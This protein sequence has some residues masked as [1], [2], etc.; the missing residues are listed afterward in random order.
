MAGCMTL[1]AIKLTP[2]SA[3]VQIDTNN[4]VESGSICVYVFGGQ[5]GLVHIIILIRFNNLSRLE[6]G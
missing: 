6:A 4:Y 5:E 3:E 2:G 1:E